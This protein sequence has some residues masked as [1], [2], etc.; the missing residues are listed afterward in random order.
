M[1][2]LGTTGRR[3]TLVIEGLF[4][5]CPITSQQ[6]ETKRRSWEELRQQFLIL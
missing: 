6:Q 5:C 1:L 4:Y 3:L 2:L